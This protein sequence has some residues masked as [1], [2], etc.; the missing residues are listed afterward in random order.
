MALTEDQ[1]VSFVH[2]IIA[3]LGFFFR[4][5]SKHDFGVDAHV[6]TSNDE[7]K[8]TG[9]N[10]ALQLKSG[11][12]YIREDS[13]Q[14]I[15]YYTDERHIQYW[16]QHSLPVILIVYSPSQR[17]AW[18][19]DVKEYCSRHPQILIN[20]PYIIRIRKSQEFGIEIKDKLLQLTSQPSFEIRLDRLHYDRISVRD[21]STSSA[22]RYTAE[23]LVGNV[24][25][26]D[27]IRLAVYQTTEY[28]KTTKEYAS[29]LQE[30]HWKDT[31]PHL[32]ML[33]VYKDLADKNQTNWI[34]RSIW[35]DPNNEAAKLVKFDNINDYVEDIEINF[36]D[37]LDHQNW[38]SLISSSVTTKTQFIKKVDHWIPQVDGLIYEAREHK[39]SFDTGRISSEDFNN[40]INDLE[41]KYEV[42][43]QGYDDRTTA[44][45]ECHE[46]EYRFVTT[47][48]AGGDVFLYFTPL[49]LKTW[50]ETSTRNYL[51]KNAFERFD[52]E[53]D[54]LKLELHKLRGY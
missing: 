10:I 15:A 4:E 18:W 53:R 12:S 17:K 6:E 39:N 37:D 35:R 11:E 49:G 44:P 30:E 28:L 47:I 20:S 23:I 31:Q 42:I 16:A 5:Q 27:I 24:V 29:L 25:N 40:V 32:I 19:C 33:F 3:E 48:Q 9:R 38:K 43:E 26:R 7:G 51:M 54:L 22:K 2:G 8:G 46:A 50:P 13:N 52:T 34:A 41:Q 21:V 45:S 36:K 1:G 14:E